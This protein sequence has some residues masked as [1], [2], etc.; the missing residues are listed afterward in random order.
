ML[1]FQFPLKKKK[2]LP[3]LET[4]KDRLKKITKHLGK[5]QL[6]FTETIL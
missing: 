6:I 1:L 4:C 5:E 2:L 3:E